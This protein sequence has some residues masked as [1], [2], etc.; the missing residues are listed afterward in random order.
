MVAIGVMLVAAQAV[1]SIAACSGCSAGPQVSEAA[2]ATEQLRCVDSA[3]T[4]DEAD[5]C[6]AKVRE[7]WGIAETV[8]DA[9]GAR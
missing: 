1:T 6:R 5:A 8:H 9:G 2:Y 4:R 3:K 7:R